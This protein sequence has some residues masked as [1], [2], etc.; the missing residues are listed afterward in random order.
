V[1]GYG[2]ICR[3]QLHASV[4]RFPKIFMIAPQRY[5]KYA[6]ACAL[7]EGCRFT[8]T[9]ITKGFSSEVPDVWRRNGLAAR[10]V[11]LFDNWRG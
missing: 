3:E 5:L 8:L 11:R 7:F 6:F 4:K 10:I 9:R 2:P 1:L